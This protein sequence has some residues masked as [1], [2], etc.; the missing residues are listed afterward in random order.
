MTLPIVV[1]TSETARL[2]MALKRNETKRC[3][4]KS[5]LFKKL[6]QISFKI[7]KRKENFVKMYNLGKTKDVHQNSV[8]FLSRTSVV[9]KIFMFLC[10]IHSAIG[11]AITVF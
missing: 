4:F 2:I 8:K 6:K 3:F 7:N 5:A 10:Y 11:A 1:Y 9:L